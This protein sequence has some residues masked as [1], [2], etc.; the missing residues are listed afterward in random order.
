M[1]HVQGSQSLGGRTAA[2]SV[3]ELLIEVLP[4]A[5]VGS[6]I[7]VLKRSSI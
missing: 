3:V 5:T 7:P 6:R 2:V 1:Q 4:E